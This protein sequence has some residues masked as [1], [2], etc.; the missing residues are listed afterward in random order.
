MISVPSKLASWGARGV[1]R[2]GERTVLFVKSNG[3]KIR[4]RKH[5]TGAVTVK[6]W[7]TQAT[8]PRGTLIYSRSSRF[9]GILF[10]EPD[11]CQ[12]KS[13]YIYYIYRKGLLHFRSNSQ[14]YPLTKLAGPTTVDAG[15]GTLLNRRPL[16]RTYL[17]MQHTFLFTSE[18]LCS[19][20]RAWIVA[21]C[22]NTSS[23]EA[24]PTQ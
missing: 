17:I 12:L 7:L 22:H 9:L 2:H 24:E 4:V 23:F 1:V 10:N 5:Q 20:S 3:P 15:T 13:K 8:P 18:Y 19:H 11:L 21:C 6:R 14:G 16:V